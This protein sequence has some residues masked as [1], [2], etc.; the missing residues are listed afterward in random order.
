MKELP[1]DLERNERLWGE[2]NP[3]LEG[4]PVD[5]IALGLL[6]YWQHVEVAAGDFKLWNRYLEG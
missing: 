2:T 3:T 5:A 4:M 1:G 6:F